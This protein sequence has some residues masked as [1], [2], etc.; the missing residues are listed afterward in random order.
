MAKKKLKIQGARILS[1]DSYLSYYEDT[2][3]AAQHRIL[4]FYEAI[5]HLESFCSPEIGFQ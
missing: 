3:D 4:G 5:R 1:D 2:K